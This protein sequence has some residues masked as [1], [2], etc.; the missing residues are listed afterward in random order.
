MSENTDE[1]EEKKNNNENDKRKCSTSRN[2]KENS[3][4]NSSLTK[5]DK[6]RKKIFLNENPNINL[7]TQNNL[8]SKRI[9]SIDENKS[10]F[11]N[12]LS[13]TPVNLGK[14]F[15]FIILK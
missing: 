9:R 1:N 2:A 7:I 14:F 3:N 12:F 4:N 13:S 11:Q 10:S 5:I 8:S 15:I 6:K